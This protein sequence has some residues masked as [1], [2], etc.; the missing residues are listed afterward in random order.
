MRRPIISI[1]RFLKPFAVKGEIKFEPYYPDQLSHKDI[2]PGFTG[3]AESA[4]ADDPFNSGKK[5]KITASR[6]MNRFWMFR[7]AEYNS[8]EEVSELTNLDLW[9]E[10]S[11]LPSLSNDQYLDADLIDCSVF[12]EEGKELGVIYD[13]IIT[14]ANDVWEVHAKDGKEIMIPV[15]DEVV[16]S[17]DIDEG[18]ITVRLLDGLLE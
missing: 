1:G 17:V 7:F 11:S 6:Q 9:V 3:V 10:R 14:G 5:I 15:I 8:P 16:L 12:D 18:K 2:K 13:V 4:E